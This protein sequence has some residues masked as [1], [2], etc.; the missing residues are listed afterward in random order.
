MLFFL[1][2]ALAALPLMPAADVAEPGL[3]AWWRPGELLLGHPDQE[4]R[5]GI[6]PLV[7]L[8]PLVLPEDLT[9]WVRLGE[10]CVSRPESSREIDGS[11]LT[12]SVTASAEGPVVQVQ[13]GDRVV[14]QNALGRPAQVCEVLLADADTIPGPEVIVA[15]RMELTGQAELRGYTVYRVPETAR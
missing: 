9:A 15:W 5:P 8:T 2:V 10:T 11:R 13:S 14:A 6:K 7:G 12:A 4:G 1:S 3:Q